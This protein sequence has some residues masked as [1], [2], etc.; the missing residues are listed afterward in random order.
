MEKK[1]REW[2]RAAG[3]IFLGVLFFFVGVMNLG[4]AWEEYTADSSQ[5]WIFGVFL[6]SVVLGAIY[7][8]WGILLLRGSNNKRKEEETE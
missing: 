8:C 1:K 6:V 3:A 2:K 7:L 5:G 4:P